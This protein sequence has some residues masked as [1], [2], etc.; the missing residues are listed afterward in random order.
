MAFHAT[1]AV[2]GKAIHLAGS[3]L[4]LGG[5]LALIFGGQPGD[6]YTAD[7]HRISTVAL[8]AVIGVALTGVVETLLFLRLS[9]LFTSS[10]GRLVLGK[11]A[12]LLGLV[13]FGAWHKYR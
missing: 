5:L 10:Y 12:G 13:A 8:V 2:P 4:W 6:R 11:L 3:S 7:A 1:Y 9:D